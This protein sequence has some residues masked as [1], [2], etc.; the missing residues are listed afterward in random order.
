MKNWLVPFLL[1]SF[2]AHLSMT[3]WIVILQDRV[4]ALEVFVREIE[5]I[6]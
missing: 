4:E 6:D 5:I 2:I 1:L 3:S